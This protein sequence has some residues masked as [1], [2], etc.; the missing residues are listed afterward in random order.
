[1]TTNGSFTMQAPGDGEPGRLPLAHT[2]VIDLS[3]A[4]AG[5][6]CSSLLGDL[7]ADVIKVEPANGGDFTR[8]WPPFQAEHSL[9]FE[10]ANRNKRSIAL[11][12]YSAEGRQ[13][14]RDLVR[15]AD[16]VLENF[17]PGTMARIGLDPER[18]RAEQPDLIVASITGFG[19]AGPLRDAAG[20]DQVA[21]GMSGLM[22]VTGPAGSEGFR[23]GVPVT[24]MVSGIFAAL[25]VAAALAAR[26]EHGRGALVGTSLLES[27][28]ALGAFQAQ[29]HL[30]TGSVPSRRATTIPR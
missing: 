17:R 12:F 10:S 29:N 8:S 18:L 6:Y 27:A 24:D 5:P 26:S 28:L 15:K 21:Q 7:G 25:G 2:T 20:L 9:Y 14:L 16:V 4:L 3:R 30:S 22:S 19:S 11:D 1:M 13:V 23:V